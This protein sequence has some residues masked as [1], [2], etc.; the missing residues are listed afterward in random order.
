MTYVAFVRAINVAGHGRISMAELRDVFTSRGCLSVRT[1][2]QSGNVVFTAPAR[3]APKLFRDVRIRLTEALGE[4]AE[5]M[6]RKMDDI[7]RLVQQ[8]PFAHVHDTSA[9]R[10]VAFLS[11]KPR[12]VPPRPILSTKEGLEVIGIEDRE[13]FI[14]SHRKVNGSFGFPNNFIEQQLGVPATSRNWSTVRR[15]CALL[16]TNPPPTEV[17]TQE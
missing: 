17:R 5:I 7:H 2:L 4:G 9:K 10:Y 13:I 15:V 16:S 3:E 6:F 8:D 12:R 14:V 11:R 1:S